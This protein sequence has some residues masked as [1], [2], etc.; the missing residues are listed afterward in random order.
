[1][2]EVTL[3]RCLEYVDELK[4]RRYANITAERFGMIILCLGVALKEVKRLREGV[5]RRGS[6]N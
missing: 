1:M 3:D 6:G 4:K 2:S 5:E